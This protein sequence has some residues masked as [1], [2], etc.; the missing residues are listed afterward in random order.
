MTRYHI[1]ESLETLRLKKKIKQSL[2][3]EGVLSERQYRRYL[4]YESEMS[5]ETLLTLIQRLDISID[6]FFSY[7]SSLESKKERFLKTL[8]TK[9]MD[10]DYQEA[11]RMIKTSHTYR[12]DEDEQ[13]LIQLYQSLIEFYERL[14]ESS[15]RDV[16]FV[17]QLLKDTHLLAVLNQKYISNTM[18]SL[19]NLIVNKTYNLFNHETQRLFQQFY[20]RLIDKEILLIDGE[21]IF[22]IQLYYSYYLSTIYGQKTISKDDT[23][24]GGKLLLDAIVLT[25]ET[26]MS[27]SLMA[28]NY[29]NSSMCYGNKS[30]ENAKKSQFYTLLSVLAQ[31]NYDGILPSFKQ[32]FAQVVDSKTFIDDFTQ[33]LDYHIKND[34][35][36]YKEIYTYDDLSTFASDPS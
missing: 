30:L 25:Q 35:Y 7:A 33:M 36:Y 12:L 16:T 15:E 3:L 19:V 14:D 1:I 29:L 11:K 17:N 21:T 4:N 20:K 28:L 8:K 10:F 6:E 31:P 2:F 5:I 22:D 13:S 34:T 26:L 23:T 24:S 27:Y 18:F 32:A 9:V